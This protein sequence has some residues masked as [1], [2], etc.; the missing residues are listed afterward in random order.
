[1]E[2]VSGPVRAASAA[3][4]DRMLSDVRRGLLSDRK[5]LPPTYFYDAKGSALFERITRTPEYYLT[6]A[7]RALLEREADSIALS[8]R[9][10]SLA[11]LGAG[12]A[13]KSRILIR[14]LRA[15]GL[16]EA[17]VPVDVDRATLAE[18]AASLR[19]EFP[20]L[21]VIPVVADIRRELRIPADAPRP[22]L[23]AF[24][25]STLGNFS[26][27][28]SQLLLSRLRGEIGKNGWLLLGADLV[29][30]AATIERAYNDA[31]GLT[32][33]FNLNVLS[34][35]NRELGADFD[36]AAFEHRAFYEPRSRRIEMHLVSRAEQRVTIPL[37]GEIDVAEGES[38]RTEISCK[39]DRES[40]EEILRESGFA[41]ERWMTGDDQSFA[42][43]LAR[44]VELPV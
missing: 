19:E 28:E 21:N 25:G 41:L 30:D 33:Q 34:V 37:V 31:E 23:C 8:A 36:L 17:Y 1:M 11:E 24:L 38:I 22:L 20:E 18:T 3:S 7:E 44:P 42:L 2:N 16:C 40:L 4:R 15:R 35:L 32:A 39:Y 13:E 14:A 9:P 29:K 27:A 12:N 6:R 5:W 10:G 43:V 26:A